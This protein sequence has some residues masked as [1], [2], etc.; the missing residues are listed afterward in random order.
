MSVIRLFTLALALVVVMTSP[1]CAGER[2]RT[3]LERPLAP[4]CKLYCYLA[5]R[6]SLSSTVLVSNACWRTCAAHCGGR[7]DTCVGASALN[8]LPWGGGSL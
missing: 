5:D 7:F 4:A 8:Q 2:D 3:K 1:A 6:M